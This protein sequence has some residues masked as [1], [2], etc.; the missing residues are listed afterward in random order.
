MLG[1]IRIATDHENGVTAVSNLFIDRY[2]TEANDA[3]I[4]I[5]LYLLRV[6]QAGRATTVPEIAD[7]FNLTE[8][9]VTRALSFWEKRD[10]VHL[11][12]DAKKRLTQIC[13]E[14]LSA[15]AGEE[16]EKASAAEDKPL[17]EEAPAKRRYSGAEMKAFQKDEALS[18]TLFAAE[19]YFGRALSATETQTILYIYD[20]LRFPADLLDYLIQYTTE[21][22]RGRF[23]SYMEKT[24]IAWHREGIRTLADAKMRGGRYDKRVYEIMRALGLSNAPTSFEAEYFNRW[25][26]YYSFPMDVIGEACRKTVMKTQSH[27]VEYADGI[28]KKWQEAGVKTLADVRASEEAFEE[29][30]AEKRAAKERTA[31]TKSAQA[32]IDTRNRFNRFKQ[33]DYNFEE[34]KNTLV[35]NK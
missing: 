1:K 34:L 10:L 19:Q 33:N 14:D 8:G 18:L 13:L 35:S 4:K 31:D 12:Y 6:M 24:A 29:R 27:R 9:D 23:A 17:Q 11:E 26:F 22:A 25:I 15:E 3:Q 20:E 30:R 5:Y 7:T 16:R 32:Q 2:M 21:N 28:L